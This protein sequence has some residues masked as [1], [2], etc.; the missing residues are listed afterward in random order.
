MGKKQPIAINRVLRKTIIY[1][2]KQTKKQ[3]ERKKKFRACVSPKLIVLCHVIQD[4]HRM[5][6][7][8]TI[9]VLRL[10][11]YV[12]FFRRVIFSN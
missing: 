11:Y 10:F 4:T 2:I 7:R 9:I 1:I 8:L 3:I 12:I 5:C 6:G